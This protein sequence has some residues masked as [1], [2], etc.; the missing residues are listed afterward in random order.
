MNSHFRRLVIA[1]RQ[2]G[3][4]VMVRTKFTIM[5]EETRTGP[6]KFYTITNLSPGRFPHDLQR[7]GRVDH[8]A[9][10]G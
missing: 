10:F 7:R 8:P 5:H 1:A 6:S 2:Q 4:H 3:L 9:P